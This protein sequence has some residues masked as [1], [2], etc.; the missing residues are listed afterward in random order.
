MVAAGDH[1]GAPGLAGGGAL[2]EQL[3]DAALH[4]A[5]L[6]LALDAQH[7]ERDA[8]APARDVVALA[9]V[10]LQPAGGAHQAGADREVELHQLVGPAGFDEGECA[11]AVAAEVVGPLGRLVE[12][13]RP[14]RAGA[15]DDGGH[16]RVRVVRGVVERL[17]AAQRVAEQREPPVPARREQIER[18]AEVEAAVVDALEA[19][20]EVAASGPVAPRDVVAARAHGER[21][22]AGLSERRAR[23]PAAPASGSSRRCRG[24]AP[25]RRWRAHGRGRL[26]RARGRR[27]AARPHP[28][29]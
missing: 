15:G 12:G 2:H 29:S 14:A 18:A 4:H 1:H 20:A 8:L 26:R 9:A 24:S 11:V 6:Q 17:G 25:R 5:R 13:G 10:L 16:P 27:P 22:V 19:G 3:G 7:R 28:P 21:A 23:C